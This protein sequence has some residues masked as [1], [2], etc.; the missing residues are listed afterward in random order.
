MGVLFMAFGATRWTKDFAV[1]TIRY[2]LP[3]GAKLFVLQLLV[4]IGDSLIQS[5]AVTFNDITASSLCILVGCSI[6]ML[7]LVKVL[8]ETMQRIVNGA[9]MASGSALVGA[10]AAVGVRP[11]SLAPLSP[12]A[13]QWRAMPFVWPP[14]RWMR[15]MT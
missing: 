12:A 9:S 10:A 5:W 1:S 14:R 15:R 4:S 6:V 11:L 13:V 7:A 8:P 2:T 3:V